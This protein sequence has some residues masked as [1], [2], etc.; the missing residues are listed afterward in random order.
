MCRTCKARIREKTYS[1]YSWDVY[2]RQLLYSKFILWLR[3]SLAWIFQTLPV[4]TQPWHDGC[5]YLI[6][7]SM[8]FHTVFNTNLFLLLW[9]NPS[10]YFLRSPPFI[11]YSLHV[12]IPSEPFHSKCLLHVHV[13]SYPVLY[14]SYPV[15]TQHILQQSIST[16]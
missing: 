15:S 5:L 12:S 3:P 6:V 14:I 16:A 13:H 9:G 2:K 4:S 1:W 11:W 10:A 8:I 7:S